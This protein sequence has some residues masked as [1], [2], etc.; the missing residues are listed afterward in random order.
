MHSCRQASLRETLFRLSWHE[1]SPIE[2]LPQSRSDLMGSTIRVTSIDLARS[3]P[4]GDQK[5]CVGES[6]I[7]KNFFGLNLEGHEA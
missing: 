7:Q 2:I 1:P 3:K 5:L 6:A 4:P